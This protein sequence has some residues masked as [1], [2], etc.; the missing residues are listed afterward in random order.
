MS[1]VNY[2]IEL[3]TQW[4]IH[5]VFHIDLLTPYHETAM[6]GPNYPRPSPELVNS[7]EEYVVEKILDSRQFG[8]GRRLQYLVKWEGYPDSDNQ[9]VDKD[10]VFADDKVREFKQ[11]NPASKTHIRGALVAHT[12]HPPHSQLFHFIDK[13]LLAV[14]LPTS[15]ATVTPSNKMSPKPLPVS[16]ES[17]QG[18]PMK[19]P[20][21]LSWS[22]PGTPLL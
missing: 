20:R 4:S 8:R 5:P 16:Q 2:R 21:L 14:S 22:P 6:H 17:S 19:G 10:D 12:A 9:W 15:S 1:T 3:P 18:L 13:C 11:L 7:E